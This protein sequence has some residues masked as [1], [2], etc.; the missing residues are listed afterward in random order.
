M[1]I[2]GSNPALA[3]SLAKLP[4]VAQQERPTSLEE[5]VVS[6]F[7]ELRSPLFRYILSFGLTAHDCEDIIQ[8]VFLA[9]FKHLQMGKPQH[10][11]RGWVFRVAHNL[12][13]KRFGANQK[14][15]YQ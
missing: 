6:L 4:K 8:E 15:R 7:D 9:L 14:I 11:L 2:R 10:N 13:V 5:D 1:P 12:S 3:L